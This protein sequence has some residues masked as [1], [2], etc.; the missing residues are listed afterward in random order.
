MVPIKKREGS[1]P[2]GHGI[3]CQVGHTFYIIVTNILAHARKY[4]FHHL[5]YLKEARSAH[6]LSDFSYRIIFV[7][8]GGGNILVIY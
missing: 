3:G 4:N 6:Q 2:V 8:G 7:G 5:T 1:F